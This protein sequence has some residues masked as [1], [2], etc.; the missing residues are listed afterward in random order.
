M[1][2]EFNFDLSLSSS[3]F[4][5]NSEGNDGNT[6]DE[7]IKPSDEEMEKKEDFGGFN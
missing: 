5:D 4:E 7:L 6:D 1:P 2:H 3:S